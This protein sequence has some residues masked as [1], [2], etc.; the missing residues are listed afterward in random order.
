MASAHPAR[1]PALRRFRAVD[2]A[3]AA[4]P[5]AGGDSR[6]G[7]RA[8]PGRREP[9]KTEAAYRAEVLGPRTDVA[10]IHYEGLTFRMGN[11][12]RYTPDWVVVTTD[13]W[14]YLIPCEKRFE[15]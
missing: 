6:T 13:G 2:S 3:K 15:V 7:R 9:N 14:R 5:G 4:R 11:G 12:H 8:S 1:S 10:A